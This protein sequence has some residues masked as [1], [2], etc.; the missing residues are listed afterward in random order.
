MN[1]ILGYDIVTYNG[2]LPNCLDPKFIPTIYEATKFVYNK[3]YS[4]FNEKWG[5][6][7]C[8]F[9]SNDYNNFSHK[10]SLLDIVNDRKNGK[11][12]PW[13]YIIEPHS[14]LDSFFGKHP[15]HN[16]FVLDFISDVA[17]DEIVN[18]DG[19]LLINYTIDGGL[20]ITTENF[21]RVVDYTRGKGISDEKV[22]LVFSDF[23]LLE[24]FK[25]LNVNYNILNYDFY[26]KFKSTEFNEVIKNRKSNNSIVNFYDFQSSIG[27]DKKDFLL[28]TRH[29]KLHRLILL[30]RLH[31]LGLDNSL[32]SWEKSYY[33]QN[34]IN[35]LIEHDN[36][37]EFIDLI[38][39]TS[40]TID[41]DDLINVKGIGHENKEMY[42]DTYISIVTESIFF[43]PD[44][45]FPTGFLSEKIWKPIGHCHPFILVGPSKSLKHIKNEY[46]YMTFHPYIDESYDDIDD[47]YQRIKMIELEIDKFS[48]K[49]KE[50]KIEFLNNVKDICKFNQEKFLSYGYNTNESI[51]ILKF[52]N[53]DIL[54]EFI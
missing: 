21:Q 23:K 38:T 13:F 27:K 14:G 41:V 48:K 36:N 8:V 43:Q 9:N 10:K 29:W 32:V 54:K 51:K 19:K 24:N 16:K 28:L 4:Y 37:L 40:K 46:G 42:L 53:G 6:D 11:N 25:N 31:R 33:D 7:Y 30:N 3:S 35:R 12:Y 47:D 45:K 22:Y 44:V 49:T 50:E 5:V 52:L 17:I 39:N 26:M 2:V 1:I 15:V 34:L 20:G 18:Y